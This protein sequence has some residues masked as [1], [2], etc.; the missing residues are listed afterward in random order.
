NLYGGFTITAAII[1]YYLAD[2]VGR[3]NFVGIF[4]LS[5]AILYLY[6]SSF[7]QSLLIGNVLVSLVTGIVVLVPVAFD[8]VPL[9]IPETRDSLATVAK[10][11][12]D[13]AVFSFAISLVREITKDMEDVEGDT[14]T[15]MNTAP[16]AF[17]LHTTKI[18]VFVLTALAVGTLLWYIYAYF[19][20]SGLWF[21]TGFL[22][23][24]AIGP[25]LFVLLRI[26][27]ASSPGE[28]RTLSTALKIVLLAGL[29]SISVVSLNILFN[30]KG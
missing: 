19:V 11:C 13:Y 28:F 16:I 6:A 14:K 30:A 20:A 4:I 22:L 3:T 9:I 24:G 17:G 26:F 7:K 15:G 1:G 27:R 12:V 10:I 18:I 8:L 29:L 5:A 25:L 21:V 23:L 2:Y